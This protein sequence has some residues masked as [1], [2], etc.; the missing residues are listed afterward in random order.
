MSQQVIDKAKELAQII[1][2][3][4]EYITMRATEDAAGQDEA[5]AALFDSY[6][7]LRAQV[8]KLSMEKEPDFDAIGDLSRDLETVQ[9]QIR[10][11][12]MYA[13]LQTARRGFSE[14]MAAVNGEL[15]AVLNPNGAAGGC[16]GNCSGCAGCN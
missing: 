7:D 4:P 16:S 3:S 9:D 1:A 14:M 13:A 6:N 11:Q 12:P 5:L 8:E 2:L 10:A 15:S